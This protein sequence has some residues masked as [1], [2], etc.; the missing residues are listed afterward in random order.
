MKKTLVFLL[1]F[2]A[3]A[4]IFTKPARAQHDQWTD[5]TYDQ[6]TGF[7]TYYC[8]ATVRI[9]GDTGHCDKTASE[10][11]E[12]EVPQ[13][14]GGS[15]SYC[16]AIP[17][18]HCTKDSDCAGGNPTGGNGSPGGGKVSC[19]KKPIQFPGGGFK[20]AIGKYVV[21]LKN[22]L[23]DLQTSRIIDPFVGL[24]S[25]FRTPSMT[26]APDPSLQYL[27]QIF[28]T[29]D[30]FTQFSGILER[31]VNALPSDATGL[32]FNDGK[33]AFEFYPGDNKG[34]GFFLPNGC[35]ESLL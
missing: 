11:Y 26:T 32:Y 20:P 28:S 18:N 23:A 15:C 19:P 13:G 22:T 1:F 6:Q 24:T 35:S 3:F 25:L 33:S 34:G 30:N 2:V 29:Y 21:S 12:C 9:C 27:H 7:I 10:F 31:A 16:G 5:P 17:Q 14:V 4:F 8:V